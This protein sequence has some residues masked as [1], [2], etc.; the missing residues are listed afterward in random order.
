MYTLRKEIDDLVIDCGKQGRLAP[1]VFTVR[2]PYSTEKQTSNQNLKRLRHAIHARLIDYLNDQLYRTLEPVRVRTVTDI[3][4]PVTIVQPSFGSLEKHAQRQAKSSPLSTSNFSAPEVVYHAH[5]SWPGFICIEDLTLPRGGRSVSVGRA[6]GNDLVLD[7]PSVARRHAT[8]AVTT[9]GT[10]RIADL[11][12]LNGTFV[13]RRPVPCR[14]TRNVR[15]KDV[16][17][18]GKAK[19]RFRKQL[20]APELG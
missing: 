2:V 20:R 9:E 10:L 7:H 16:V 15:E 5:I 18:L 14:Q 6:E 12:S 13:N 4:S 17:S 19:V 3:Y 11:G 1:H 8:L